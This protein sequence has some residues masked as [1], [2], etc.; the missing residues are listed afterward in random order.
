[1]LDKKH[2]RLDAIF[3]TNDEMALGAVDALRATTSP[4]SAATVVIGVDGVPEAR[5]LI[6]AGTSPLRATVVQDAHHLAENAVHVLERMH[7][8]RHVPK[9]TVLRPEVYQAE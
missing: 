1:M 3:C 6:G 4:A 5:T 8:D 2:G 7:N 9:R